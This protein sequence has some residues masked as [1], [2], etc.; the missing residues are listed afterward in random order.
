MSTTSKPSF[1]GEIVAEFMG[2]LVLITLGDGVVA[3][4]NLFPGKPPV[5]G[6]RGGEKGPSLLCRKLPGLRGFGRN[7]RGGAFSF[8]NSCL[9]TSVRETP[10]SRRPETGVSAT[11]VPKQEFGNEGLSR[12]PPDSFIVSERSKG[13][14]PSHTPKG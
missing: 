4:V 14:T 8:P 13:G 10:V 1:F 6:G 7:E 3:M 2:H 5:P 11:S 9:G 12:E